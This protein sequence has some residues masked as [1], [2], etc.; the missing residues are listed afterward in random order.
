MKFKPLALMPT[1]LHSSIWSPERPVSARYHCVSLLIFLPVSVI[2]LCTDTITV[3]SFN[4]VGQCDNANPVQLTTTRF[5]KVPDP[6]TITFDDVRSDSLL[7]H[8]SLPKDS[9]P[10]KSISVD[11]RQADG[12]RGWSIQN[13]DGMEARLQ[14]LPAG[15]QLEVR[16]VARNGSGQGRYSAVHVVTTQAG[17]PAPPEV[18]VT[19]VRANEATLRC[20]VADCCGDPVNEI[21]V[22]FW[23]VGLP[24]ERREQSV[25]VSNGASVAT[26]S[27]RQ[28]EPGTNYEVSTRAVNGIGQSE[29]DCDPDE[30]LQQRQSA[31]FTTT[32]MST[33]GH[34]DAGGA[35]NTAGGS[36]P[37]ASV[38]RPTPMWLVDEGTGAECVALTWAAV[39]HAREYVVE[40]A[41]DTAAAHAER[42]IAADISGSC[43]RRTIEVLGGSSMSASASAEVDELT[44]MKDML[45]H[46]VLLID[47]IEQAMGGQD[48]GADLQMWM[49]METVEADGASTQLCCNLSGLTENS[50]Y[51]FRVRCLDA[52][53]GDCSA[54]IT[55]CTNAAG[56]TPALI[57]DV[58]LECDDSST[59]SCLWSA[60]GVA[61]RYELQFRARGT[62]KQRDGEHAIPWQRHFTDAQTLELGGFAPGARVE[63]RV[64]S[65][66]LGGIGLCALPCLPRNECTY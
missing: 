56:S 6:P 47:E 54:K 2:S 14:Q 43:L 22:Y 30:K 9:A 62:G 33:P 51:Q 16:A 1:M 55:R 20:D 52:S 28:L 40:M 8:L 10:A 18:T 5:T 50:W 36:P 13:A 41:L 4:S 46:N 35:S 53:G 37:R 19:A 17:P 27:L 58:I 49:P 29:S 25:T 38:P 32:P 39:Q 65:C 59:V 26:V 60:D 31:V 3:K 44:Q 34:T 21:R 66:G 57:T 23:P 48:S 7:V 64:R 11:W 45:E 61:D 24:L 15:R 42:L 12:F 63:V